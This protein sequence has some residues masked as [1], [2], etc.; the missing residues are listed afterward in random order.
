MSEFVYEQ[1]ELPSKGQLYP[2]EWTTNGKISVR[3]LTIREEK[4]LSTVRLVKTGKALDMVFRACI[5]KPEINVSEL[6]SGDRSFL[7]FYLRC[8]SYGAAYEYK[9]NCPACNTQFE[10]IFNLNEITT[11]YLAD[12]F[13]EPIDF[14]LPLSKK[15]VAYKLMRG[16][17]ELAI[18]E[19]QERRL[20]N[21][22]ADQID[23]TISYK[24]S[25][26]IELVENVTDKKE[27]EKFVD[28]MLAG[29]AA[30]LRQDMNEKDCG[31][32]IE[33]KHICPKCANEFA[34]D[35]PLTVDFFHY[36]QAKS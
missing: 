4:I 1:V 18:L 20:S 34:V 26:S 25:R 28:M 29:D 10:N 16:A 3:A 11:R 30:A 8:I 7:L 33:V 23:N 22:S 14:T 35:L 12:N 19:D 6:L 31:V 32:D 2:K 21:F 5:Q 9:I 15:R 17:D 13:K 27:I 24:L 36:S